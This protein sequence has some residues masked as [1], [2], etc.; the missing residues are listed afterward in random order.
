MKRTSI[1]AAISPLLGCVGLPSTQAASQKRIL[2]A[3]SCKEVHA[4]YA[5]YAERDSLWIPGSKHYIYVTDENLDSIL[6]KAGLEDHVLFGDFTICGGSLDDPKK[7]TNQ[8]NVTIKSYRNIQIR[9][10]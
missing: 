8:S 5:I 7:L 9:N 2:V 3:V 1:V 6:Q 10:R 4:R